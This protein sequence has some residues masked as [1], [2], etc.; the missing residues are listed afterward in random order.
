MDDCELNR[1]DWSIYHS[2]AR[3]PLFS[4]GWRGILHTSIA[5][6]NFVLTIGVL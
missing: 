4:K 2:S 1:D 6:L 3:G 5:G